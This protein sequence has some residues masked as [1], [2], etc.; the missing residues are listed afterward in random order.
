M[1]AYY[2]W[3]SIRL[4][5]GKVVFKNVP[6]RACIQR[7]QENPLVFFNQHLYT[8]SVTHFVLWDWFLVLI[9][10][11]VW[12]IKNN[13]IFSHIFR[14]RVPHYTYSRKHTLPWIADV[15]QKYMYIIRVILRCWLGINSCVFFVCLDIKQSHWITTL[16][17]M[18]PK[19]DPLMHP[20]R[21]AE[22]IKCRDSF[23]KY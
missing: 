20:S 5:K 23:L 14:V 7:D 6:I 11:F 21:T 13:L 15:Q 8:G 19:I 16:K 1:V 17:G 9:L 2:H 22:Y 3:R 18:K 10:K 12:V 4:C